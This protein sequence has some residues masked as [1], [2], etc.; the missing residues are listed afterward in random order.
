MKDTR[1][2]YLSASEIGRA[3]NNRQLSPCEVVNYFEDRIIKKNADINAFVY[4]KFEYA[5]EEAKKLEKRIMSGEQLGDF[6]GVPFAL[7]DFL[8]SKKS[9]THSHGGVK[10]LIKEDPY[11]SVFCEAMERAGGIAIG[12]TNSPAYGFR[13]TCDNKLYG[14]TH[15]PFNLAYNSG[16]SSGGS[17]AAVAA[18]MVPIAEGGDAG[19]SI[20]LP[21]AWCNCV[22][23]KAALGTIPSVC[24]PDAWSATHPFCFNGGITKSVEDTANLLT[25]MSGYNPRDPYSVARDTVFYRKYLTQDLR[26]MKI[27]Y[28]PDFGIFSVD[29]EVEKVVLEAVNHFKELGATVEVIDK[30]NL[31]YSLKELAEAWCRGICIDTAIELELWKE[32]G[33]DPIRD[34]RDDFPEEFI[35]WNEIAAKSTILDYY[36]F[37]TVRTSI[38]DLFENIFLDYD[39]VISPTS[40]CL[41]VLNADD[42]NTKGPK[43]INQ[44][45]VEQLIGFAETFLANLSGHPAISIP[46][47]FSKEGLPIGMQ[48][49]GKKLREGNILAASA[50]FERLMPWKS[51]YKY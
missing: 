17:A 43:E 6:A 18:G 12:K 7:K 11:D 26:G 44:T 2:E 20:R 42:G 41:P 35:Y 28:T 8:P 29:P 39:L 48:I 13:A 37:N 21:A 32:Q 31:S 34:H 10:C 4:T 36:R 33:F 9:W 25:Y 3:V 51:Y 49:I 19:G 45:T 15:N 1:L 46:A 27:A 47:G 14:P 30:I 38:L 22:G 23:Y 24:R 16:G 5:E 40:A 50:A